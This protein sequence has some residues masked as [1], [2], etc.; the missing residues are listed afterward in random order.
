MS[1][2]IVYTF[3]KLYLENLENNTFDIYGTDPSYPN[4]KND[5]FVQLIHSKY[6][7]AAA[8][9]KKISRKEDFVHKS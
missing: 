5:H 7:K 2:T 1:D 6:R 4:F 8:L 3:L 9:Q